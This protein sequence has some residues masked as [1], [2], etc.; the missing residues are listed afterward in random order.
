MRHASGQ[1]DL[2]LGTSDNRP[3][4]LLVDDQAINIQTMYQI[5]H[6]DHEVFMATSGA[7]ALE[8]CQNK[9]PDLILLDVVM[10]DMDGYEVCRQLKNDPL[11]QAIP[12]IFVTAQDNP[13][14]EERGLDIGAVDFISK[15]VNPKVVRARVRTHLTL[16]RQSDL[17]RSLA[18]VDG[19]TGVANRRNFD[20]TLK[21]E[22]RRC[23]RSNQTL[24]L[25]ILDIDFFKRYNDH[26]GHQAG[27]LCLCA[28]ATTLRKCANRSHDLVARY[29]GEE[30]VCILPETPLS[31]AET[32]AQE[33]ELA[34]RQ[35][36]IVHAQSDIADVVTI[37]LG[38]AAAFHPQSEGP[39][40]L[41]STADGLLYAAK[42]AGR[43]QYK[44]GHVA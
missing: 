19:L 28:V 14:D 25:I 15:P 1:V 26:Y 3:C 6:N 42:Q 2:L 5:F 13:I 41:I 17:L 33:M 18:F 8:F 44:V 39:E 30:F 10:P 40:K 37:S 31:G 23:L 36:G 21:S 34:V 24:S 9:Q 22:W 11:T 38:V 27:D 4:L 16:K 20:E 7:Q 32:M 29:G 35:L 12:V 43:G